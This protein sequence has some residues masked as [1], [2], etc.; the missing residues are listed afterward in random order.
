M[1]ITSWLRKRVSNSSSRGTGQRRPCFR[2]QL[3][4]LDDRLVPSTLTVT[5]NLDNS[6]VGSLRYGS[7]KRARRHDRLAPSLDGQTIVLAEREL[8]ITNS[9]RSGSGR[10]PTDDRRLG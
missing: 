7:A 5:N 10:R 2:P 6:S 3:E 9:L 8:D 4:A 1:S